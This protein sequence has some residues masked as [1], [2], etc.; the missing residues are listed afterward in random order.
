MADQTRSRVVYHPESHGAHDREYLL[1]L[2]ARSELGELFLE[3]DHPLP[4]GTVLTL[5]IESTRK[6]GSFAPMR[7]RAVVCWRRRWGKPRGMQVVFFE[8]E[9]LGQAY[10]APTAGVPW[11]VPTV[12]ALA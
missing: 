4:P 5:E 1:E 3:T 12:P 9:G 7:G 6:D 2:A 10:P 11:L 8:I